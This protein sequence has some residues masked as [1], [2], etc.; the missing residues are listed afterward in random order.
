MSI[1]ARFRAG[2]RRGVIVLAQAVAGGAL[3]TG[4]S[5][6]APTGD[7]TG[8]MNSNGT[9]GGGTPVDA[10]M[11]AEVPGLFA[12]DQLWTVAATN[13]AG[14]AG[15][16]VF[17]VGDVVEFAG[18]LPTDS[19]FAVH[20]EAQIDYTGGTLTLQ[21]DYSTKEPG[22]QCRFTLEAPA[23][24]CVT[25]GIPDATCD[26]P[27]GQYTLVDE[28][29]DVPLVSGGWALPQP[30]AT[31]PPTLFTYGDWSIVSL[32]PLALPFAVPANQFGGTFI[33]VAGN[34]STVQ[35]ASLCTAIS[36]T[37]CTGCSGVPAQ[38]TVTFDGTQLVVNLTFTESASSCAVSFTGQA[39]ACGAYVEQGTVGNPVV[40]VVGNGTYQ[41]D[42]VTGE[43]HVLYF[44]GSPGSVRQ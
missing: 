24:N 16:L 25:N 4:C 8:D 37:D 43:I 42:G 1:P 11:P 21:T 3:L 28:G 40:R 13:A 7:N 44:T 34:S 35:N 17:G 10:T 23:A 12:A 9:F 32:H 38:G 2:L 5:G 41:Q 14:T 19:C 30:C 33:A 18:V 27:S 6:T 29:T 26:F 39:Q 31:L 15:A 22:S 20:P 36:G